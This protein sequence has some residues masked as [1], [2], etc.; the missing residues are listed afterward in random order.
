MQNVASVHVT[1]QAHAMLG[2]IVIA[3]VSLITPEDA[4]TFRTRLRSYC[5]GKLQPHEVPA[6][7]RLVA[8]PQLSERFKR[9]RQNSVQ[10]GASEHQTKA[11]A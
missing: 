1:G 3:D 8:A 11:N 10:A 5:A 6:K 4:T 9:V 2:Q 7:V